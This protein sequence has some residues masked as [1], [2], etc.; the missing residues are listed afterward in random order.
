MK[1]VEA[2]HRPS[3]RKVYH[4]H[5]EDWK[6]W[7]STNNVKDPVR[8]SPYH[9]ANYL[10]FL[11]QTRK[12]SAATLK[13]RRSAISSVLKTS[14]VKDTTQDDIVS[15]VISGVENMQPPKDRFVPEWDVAVVL[16]FLKGSSFKSN[17]EIPLT[18]LSYKTAFL[19]ALASGRRVS[20]ISNFSGLKEDI[21][22]SQ[23][24]SISLKFLPEF[25]AKN[26]VPGDS[27]PPILIKPLNKAVDP[28]EEDISICPVR[29]LKEYRR[30]TDPIRSPRQRALFI[31]V[32][33]A[34]DSD[35]SR[36]SI[37]RWLKNLICSAYKALAR[38]GKKQSNPIS[39]P[40]SIRAHEIRAW[41]ATM[42]SK[43]TPLPEVMKA[44]YWKTSTVFIRHYLRDV[45]R[46]SECGKQRL[47]AMVAAQS[48]F[49]PRQ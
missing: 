8:P 19:I 32:N 3:T 36:A 38:D 12:L 26:Q 30:R 20:E 45:S 17:R 31:S 41:A 6:K 11:S 35:L 27:S 5:W 13:T 4:N 28:Q 1:C 48:I 34:H 42:A 44:A 7:C 47:P 37:S 49:N 9:I 18:A 23:D 10:S 25:L 46:R 33:P 43:T 24:G 2:H 21:S 14:G 22:H 39:Q 16:N 15:Q 40:K 29:A